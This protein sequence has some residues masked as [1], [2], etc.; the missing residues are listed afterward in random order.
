[1]ERGSFARDGST[2]SGIAV[3]GST[4]DL[5][6]PAAIR[7]K[8]AGPGCGRSLGCVGLIRP[9][10]AS[11]S[12]RNPERQSNYDLHLWQKSGLPTSRLPFSPCP[13]SLTLKNSPEP[14]SGVS[15][16]L[17]MCSTS[18]LPA[19]CSV[20]AT[21][22]AGGR[23]AGKRRGNSIRFLLCLCSSGCKKH[24]PNKKCPFFSKLKYL[25]C[26]NERAER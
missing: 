2:N 8:K 6:G 10:S 24:F 7:R 9:R 18:R 4:V 3:G 5:Q 26:P 15:T 20:K 21:A 19:I 17:P 23:T 25:G 11:A 13:P 22:R 12:E 1:M 14:E 16:R